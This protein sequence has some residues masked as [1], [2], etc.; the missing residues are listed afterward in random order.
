MKQLWQTL[1]SYLQSNQSIVHQQGEFPRQASVLM[2]FTDSEQHP[3]IIF[4]LRAMHLSNHPGEVSFPGG[5]WEPQDTTLLDTALRESYEE[6][7]LL[8]TQVQLLG[9]CR[10]RSTRAG[11]L[12]TPF[13]GV[14]PEHVELVPNRSELDAI[15]RVPLA[16][17]HSGMIQT[18]TDIFSHEGR[19]YRVPAYLHQGYEIWGFT[20]ALTHEIISAIVVESGEVSLIQ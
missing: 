20:A 16:A 12:V 9:A 19:S 18:R 8:P 13:V 5:M 14:I 10:S 11:V 17:F 1:Q 3:E 15:F 2:L 4:T 6:I 7:N